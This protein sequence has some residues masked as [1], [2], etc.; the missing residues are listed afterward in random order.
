MRKRLDEYRQKTAPLIEYY[1]GKGLLEEISGTG[2]IEEIQ[3]QIRRAVE[4]ARCDN[5]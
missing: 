4:G 5:P 2:S 3:V 1:S